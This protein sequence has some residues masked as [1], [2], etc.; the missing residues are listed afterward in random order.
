MAAR[1]Y[2]PSMPQFIAAGEGSRIWD[3]DG[4]EYIDYMCSWGPIILGHHH[5]VVEAAAEAQRRQ[6]DCLSGPGPVL[7]ELAELFVATVPHADWAMF[8]KN[9][10]DVTTLSLMVA[11]AHTRKRA[12]LAA[13]GS[14]HGAAPWCNPWPRGLLAE[15]KAHIHYF[16]YNDLES[17][18]AAAAEVGDD[19]AGVIVTP[20]RHDAGHDQED[21]DPSFARGLR[22]LCDA[23]GA[24]LILDDVRAGLRLDPGGAGSR[25][26]CVPT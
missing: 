23:T 10:T 19:L 2:V 17:A 20:F 16:R 13:A 6:G 14:Y 11:R 26:A 9:G 15:D 7:V 8:A 21:V 22:A 5:P 4:R 12:I 1:D 25:S 3:A 18:R 24:A